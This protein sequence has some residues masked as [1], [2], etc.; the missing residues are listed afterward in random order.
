MDINPEHELSRKIPRYCV[1][2][3]DNHQ[4]KIIGNCDR[5]M[6]ITSKEID[7]SSLLSERNFN[8]TRGLYINPIWNSNNHLIFMLR[9]GDRN[10]LPSKI[11]FHQE[12]SQQIQNQGNETFLQTGYE[13]RLLCFKFAWRFFRGHKMVICET[14]G[15]SKYDPFAGNIIWYSGQDDK[16]FFDFSLNNLQKKTLKMVL[17]YVVGEPAENGYFDSR[18]LSLLSF[19][20]DDLPR[21]MNCTLYQE[22]DIERVYGGSKDMSRGQIF[23]IDLIQ[24]IVEPKSNDM[25]YS[26]M[27]FSGGLE[28]Q[29]LCILTPHSSL[30][31]QSLVGFKSFT[32]I[33]W[34][35]ILVTLSTF[36]L[37]QYVFQ[38]V[39]CK[40]L[41]RL[42]SETEISQYES[43]SAILTVYAYFI[44][45]SPPQLLLGR[46]YTGKILFVIFSFSS[47]IISSVFLSCMTS[48][49]ADTVQYPEIDSLEDLEASDLLIQV[50]DVTSASTIFSSLGLSEVLKGKL[51][52]NLNH[53]VNA[54]INYIAEDN[55]IM[56]YIT[57]DPSV[58]LNITSEA[59]DFSEKYMRNVHSIQE[60][61]AFLTTMP[62]SIFSKK[63][64]LLSVWPLAKKREYHKVEEYLLTKPFVYT[65]PRNSFFLDSVKR[66]IMLFMESGLSGKILEYI[67]LEGLLE[68]APPPVDDGEPRPFNMND[69][70]LGFISL[71]VGLFI[72]FLVFIAEVLNDYYKH[73]VFLKHIKRFTVYVKSKFKQ[74][75]INAFTAIQGLFRSQKL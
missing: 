2:V 11:R 20:L 63:D 24:V 29:A 67:M 30:L 74:G 46:L 65:F 31:P 69:L 45:G 68:A 60:A 75:Y 4:S 48:L 16:T 57:I 62:R 6:S 51:V 64:I 18:M 33:V 72:S 73:T 56:S 25:D 10:T 58:H 13:A 3:D 70:Q 49:M 53:Y 7:G 15:C 59:R 44:C 55:G 5:Y 37:M 23:D 27:E 61:D 26:Q 28:T 42:Y 12:E 9:N 50:R 71:V 8:L 43:S 35:H 41:R 39:H 21:S 17:N 36:L 32:F 47:P 1:N 14:S 22:S 40:F 34:I 66:L 38:R 19:I 54:L 52:N